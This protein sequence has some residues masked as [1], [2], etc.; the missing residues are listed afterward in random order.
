MKKLSKYQGEYTRAVQRLLS[1]GLADHS[2]ANTKLMQAK[3]PSATQPSSFRPQPSDTPQLSFTS[4]QVLKS[5]LSFRKGSAPGPSGLRAE[6]LR[7]A[8]QSAPPN[9]RARALEAVTRLVNIMSAGDVPD[10]VA[11]YLSGARMQ[12]G[13]KKDGGLRPIAVGN[14]L[15]RLTSKCSMA[16]VVEKAVTML[17]PHQ[18]GVGVNGGLEAVIHAVIE[19]VEEADEELMLLQVDFI[20][21]FNL[22]D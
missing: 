18:L 14:L 6:H 7:A 15:R 22:A 4:D 5:I 19:L 1:T 17:S 12:A 16:G 8:T 10:L 13:L 3:H 11:P 2:R 21:A 9:R 20:N